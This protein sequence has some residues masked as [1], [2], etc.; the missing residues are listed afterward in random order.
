MIVHNAYAYGFAAQ[1][2]FNKIAAAM[3]ILTL[4]FSREPKRMPA[5]FTVVLMVLFGIWGGISA[6]TSIS[7]Q[8]YVV[9]YLER[10]VKIIVF[11]LMI[12]LVINTRERIEAFLY[13]ICLSLG[14]HG[15]LAGAKF[16]ASGGSSRINGP[17]QSI[18]GDNNHLALAMVVLLPM[19]I[20]LY[21]QANH[22]LLKYALMGSGTLVAVAV[23]GTF[24]RGGFLGIASIGMLAFVRSNRKGRFV[25]IVVPMVA[26]AIAFA[27]DLWSNRMDSI[28]S[29]D[30]D[31]SFMGRVIAWKQSTLIA[32][33][34]PV[35]GGG[36]HAV[37]DFNVWIDTQRNFKRLDFIP[38]AEPSQTIAYAAHSIYFEVLGDLGFGGLAIFILI[39]LTSWRNAAL[40]IRH[41]KDREA[42]RWAGELATGLQYS[43][44]AYAVSGAALSMA[45][46][47]LIYVVCALLVVMRAMVIN[48]VSLAAK[49]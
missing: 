32:M 18:I 23:M 7:S 25:A 43:L 2:P 35:F 24:S 15:V 34:N 41:S 17:G 37:Q 44:I 48:D 19:V 13:A 21:R 4:M 33:A 8:G 31:S 40:I 22:R 38:T 6:M 29:A 47:D 45:Y 49:S 14:F 27:P 3:A 46:F 39:L 28:K 42:W 16:L 26:L 9:D 12:V 20:Y 1:I 30:Q 36:F 11:V 5:N 10:L